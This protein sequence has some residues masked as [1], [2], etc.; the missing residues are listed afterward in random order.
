MF[1][2]GRLY[3]NK[4]EER[5]M[6][7]YVREAECSTSLFL[8]GILLLVGMLKEI[9]VLNAVTQLYVMFDPNI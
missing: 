5:Q 4:K 2:V 1:L 3:R 9:G 6:L 8:L 7:G